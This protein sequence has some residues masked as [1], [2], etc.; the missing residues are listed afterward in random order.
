MAAARARIALAPMVTA[1]PG[2][3]LLA[4]VELPRAVA[5]GVAP[6]RCA[7]DRSHE[8]L[9]SAPET[10]APPRAS[11][12]HRSPV[13]DLR[14]WMLGA[15]VTHRQAPIPRTQRNAQARIGRRSLSR[16]LPR[17]DWLRTPR[18]R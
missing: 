15:A 10:D 11:A 6:T 1:P 18:A 3:T 5:A 13:H 12:G 17:V 9:R 16:Y 4:T 2:P 7:L 14:Q 8:S